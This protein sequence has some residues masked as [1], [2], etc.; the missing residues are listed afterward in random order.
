[1]IRPE[2]LLVLASVLTAQTAS[3]QQTPTAG[4]TVSNATII[5]APAVEAPPTV[6]VPSNGAGLPDGTA[7]V[8][9]VVAAT[10]TTADHFS[11]GSKKATKTS[12]TETTTADG[13]HR[14]TQTTSSTVTVSPLP[15]PSVSPTSWPVAT[16]LKNTLRTWAQRQGWPAPQFLTPV[17]WA[18]D[19]PGSI[20]GSI[21]DAL[22]ALTEGFGKSP[23][24]PRIEV[25]ANH[26]M[27]V[28]EI[29]AE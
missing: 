20:S 18:V 22:K 5:S 26:V 7:M 2:I 25:S 11:A 10:P 12:K 4:T 1:M 19:V 8:L 21:E 3:A 27:L 29:G 14:E 9:P 17:D 15:T 6:I 23:S 16:S 24:R 28:S 13:F